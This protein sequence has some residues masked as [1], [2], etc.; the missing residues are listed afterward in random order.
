MTK[1]QG[2]NQTG[3]P[4]GQLPLP[5]Q[6]VLADSSGTPVS[7]VP[8]VFQ[9][10]PGAQVSS[11]SATTDSLGR[12]SAYLRLPPA[13][14]AA[15]VN[16][17]APSVS[18]TSTTFYAMAQA[19]TLS[20]FPG[21]S[22]LGGAPLGNGMATIG[23]KGALLDSVASI[24]RFGQNRG[25][26]PSPNGLAD[27]VALNQFLTAYCAPA[28]GA[29]LCDGFLSNPGSGE[30]IVN[31]WRAAEFTGGVDVQVQT[32]SLAALPDLLAGGEP[33]LLSLELSLNGRPMGGH[34][35]DAIGIAADG[36]IV[37][38]DPNPLFARTNLNDYLNGFAGTGGT[39]SAT[40]AGV[41]RFA[42]SAP[43]A[44]RFMLGE[45]S[46]PVT[47]IQ[48]MAL[49]VQSPAG[50]CGQP[51][52]LMDEV[53]S[54]GN[55]PPAGA[56]LSRIDVCDGLQPSYQVDL[57]TAQPYRAF[58][59]DLAPGGSSIDL[60]GQSP[61]T[62]LATRPQLNL[63]LAPQA[64]AIDAGGVVNAASFT[65]GIAPGGMMAIFGSGL[66][67]SAAATT[68]DMDGTAATVIAASPFQVNA[69]VPASI[70]PGTHILRIVSPFGTARQPVT[71][72]TVAPAIF[73]VGNPASGAVENQNYT[74][75]S[76]TNPLPRGQALAV[77][78]TGLGAVN[79]SGSYFTV[80][81]PRLF[82]CRDA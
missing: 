46:Q 7:G 11:A 75:N 18:A 38:Q 17:S 65:S 30:Q 50:A 43:S 20:N 79:K 51:L 27:P 57:G 35:V 26:L 71:V 37:I 81:S 28:Q 3:V 45:L 29:P 56:L 80:S 12:A 21:F 54:G 41:V 14:G 13:A 53:D 32:P 67:G 68:V 49:A 60:S 33:L 19:T 64:A 31:L 44:T 23:Q 70:A 4:G 82:A 55:P 39:W 74:L 2:D 48:K 77:Y 6:A 1:A 9:A 25:E 15:L 40:L 78:A 73:L 58:V 10:S 34:F 66:A 61:G 69:Q 72:S 36:S 24:L 8:V 42:A 16:V 62:F 59:T 22:Q 76:P 47:L 63:V 52:L 5:L